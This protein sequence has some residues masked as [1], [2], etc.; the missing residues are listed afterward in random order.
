VQGVGGEEE[1]KR[2]PLRDLKFQLHVGPQLVGGMG[3]ETA[4]HFVIKQVPAVLHAGS[5]IGLE[6]GRPQRHESVGLGKEAE[7]VGR[8]ADFLGVRMN[9]VEMNQDLH[10]ERRFMVTCTSRCWRPEPL[11]VPRNGVASRKSRPNETE[12]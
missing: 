6:L 8:E 7:N 2:I 1:I 12:T 11:K 3:E 10:S 4:R 5:L 9:G